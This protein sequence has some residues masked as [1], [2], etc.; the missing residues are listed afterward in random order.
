M[1][2]NASPLRAKLSIKC[3]HHKAA[4]IKKII[5]VGRGSYLINLYK[6]VILH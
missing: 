6:V 1:H 5:K 3:S 2:A 4:Q